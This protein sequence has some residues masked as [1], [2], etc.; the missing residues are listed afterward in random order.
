MPILKLCARCKRV[1]GYAEDDNDKVC[2][3]CLVK[4]MKAQEEKKGTQDEQEDKKE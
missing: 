4:Q 3:R 1:N 2:Y